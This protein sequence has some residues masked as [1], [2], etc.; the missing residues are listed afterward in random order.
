MGMWP[1]MNPC[2]F[3]VHCQ[4]AAFK[5][6]LLFIPNFFSTLEKEFWEFVNKSRNL[7]FSYSILGLGM[8]ISQTFVEKSL[9]K[10][11]IFTQFC[12]QI[13]IIF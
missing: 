10:I 6:F 12:G 2:P 8:E 4:I 1:S 11:L 3:P 13:L 5:P 9:P 7:P